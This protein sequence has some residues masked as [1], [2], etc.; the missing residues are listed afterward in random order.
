M[1]KRKVVN[2]LFFLSR[3][4]GGEFDGGVWGIFTHFLSRLCGGE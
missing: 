4:C 3:L 2:E 1:V